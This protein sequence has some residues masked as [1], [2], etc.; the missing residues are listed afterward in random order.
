M[1]PLHV[2]ALTMFQEKLKDIR[3]IL[4]DEMS[5]IGLKLLLKI[6]S[7]LHKAFPHHKHSYFGGISMI[8][9]GD[10][11]QLPPIMDKPI[12][13]S[14]SN[15]ITLWNQFT[16]IITLKMMFL[17]QGESLKKSQFRQTLLNIHSAHLTQED[18]QSLMTRT[19]DQ[20]APTVNKQFDTIV[21]LFATN[22]MVTLHNK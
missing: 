19:K 11:T 4:I 6:D 5:F 3:Y 9:I 17:Q 10:L 12:Y 8:L 21:H 13:T 16:T 14:H 15:A 2:Q 18:W 7:Q 20:L 1:Q 22:D